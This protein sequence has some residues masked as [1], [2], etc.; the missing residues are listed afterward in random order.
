MYVCTYL[1]LSDKASVVFVKITVAAHHIDTMVLNRGEGKMGVENL[2]TV[3]EKT[4]AKKTMYFH[5]YSH[6]YFVVFLA[7]YE[8]LVGE[9]QCLQRKRG[10]RLDGA[11]RGGG[12]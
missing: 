11:V 3:L 12:A 10:A 6:I 8:C 7:L 9:S 2:L 5:L 1:T 4:P